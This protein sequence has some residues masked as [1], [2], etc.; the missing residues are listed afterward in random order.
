MSKDNL[1]HAGVQGE[2]WWRGR[3]QQ[4]KAERPWVRVNLKA[5]PV[6]V[7]EG[8]DGYEDAEKRQCPA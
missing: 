3:G 5:E 6:P 7:A 8:A 1:G 2:G 4:G